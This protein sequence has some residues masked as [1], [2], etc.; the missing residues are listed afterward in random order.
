M[1]HPGVGFGPNAGSFVFDMGRLKQLAVSPVERHVSMSSR[2]SA[3]DT[4]WAASRHQAGKQWRCAANHARITR[5][6]EGNRV[7]EG[8]LDVSMV[9]DWVLL[10]VIGAIDTVSGSGLANCFEG[11]YR[12]QLRHVLLDL[13]EVDRID[14][15]GAA[16]LRAA[17]HHLDEMGGEMRLIGLPAGVIETMS[18]GASGPGVTVYPTFRAAQTAINAQPSK[19]VQDQACRPTPRRHPAVNEERFGE[20]GGKH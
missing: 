7:W 12:S 14:A 6:G 15:G 13:S 18:T 20:C 17:Q 9:E 16:L 3:M 8:S 11:L 1:F 5:E 4:D 2:R 10:K 19:L